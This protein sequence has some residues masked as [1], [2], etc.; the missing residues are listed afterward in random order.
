MRAYRYGPGNVFKR[1]EAAVREAVV[2]RGPERP[3]HFN[4]GKRGQT[5]L[6]RR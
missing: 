1:G 4:P 2:V 3:L 5:G 6:S